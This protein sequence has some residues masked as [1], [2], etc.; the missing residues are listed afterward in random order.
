MT[1]DAAIAA[2]RATLPRCATTGV[3][4]L[5]AARLPEAIQCQIVA[6]TALGTAKDGQ[7][8]NASAIALAPSR[9]ETSKTSNATKPTPSAAV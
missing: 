5:V 1:T 2:T 8:T 4:F 9:C 7:M 3:W 6:T